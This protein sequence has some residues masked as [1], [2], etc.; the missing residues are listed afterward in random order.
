MK[1]HA[2]ERIWLIVGGAMLVLFLVLLSAAAFG[3]GLMPP[4][5]AGRVDPQKLAQDPRFATPGLKA[6]SAGHYEVD[7]VAR[8]FTFQPNQIEIPR[9]AEVKFVVTSPD[10]IHGFEIAGTN[11]N[12]MVV[13]GYIT[14]M[15][16]H[17][18]KP[19]EYLI[20]C[21][22]YCGAGHQAMMGKIVVK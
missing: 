13:P 17:F 6:L 19:G 15:S 9:G 12:D 11:V 18:D 20:L 1:I 5:D 2:I 22:E 21:N 3:E 14:E 7:A 4:G 8:M 16:A 10:V